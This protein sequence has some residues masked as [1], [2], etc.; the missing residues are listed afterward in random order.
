MSKDIE[1]V[2][3]TLPIEKNSGTAGFTGDFNKTFTDLMS[4]LLKPF[5]KIKKGILHYM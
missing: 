5:P 2:I 4:I 3:K 1:S